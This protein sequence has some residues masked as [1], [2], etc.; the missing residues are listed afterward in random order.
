MVNV[1]LAPC[2]LFP[3]NRYE[4]VFPIVKVQRRQKRTST[5]LTRSLESICEHSAARLSYHYHSG[6]RVCVACWLYKIHRDNQNSSTW[7]VTQGNRPFSQLFRGDER[8]R[9]R[10]RGRDSFSRFSSYQNLILIHN[11]ALCLA[12]SLYAN[13]LMFTC[14]LAIYYLFKDAKRE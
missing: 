4:R 12:S 5:P 3:C 6:S 13:L 11:L 9:E 1:A 2:F 8:T 7:A 10:E 14:P